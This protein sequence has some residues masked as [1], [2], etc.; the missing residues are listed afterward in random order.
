MALLNLYL[1]PTLKCIGEP[2]IFTNS[3]FSTEPNTGILSGEWYFD[4][5]LIDNTDWEPTHIFDSCGIDYY[6]IILSIEDN[7]GCI[8]HDTK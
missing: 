1:V 4:I 2:T 6:D 7:N 3:S 5:N 8:N